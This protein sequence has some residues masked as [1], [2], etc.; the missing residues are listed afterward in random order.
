MFDDSMMFFKMGERANRLT[1]WNAAYLVWREANPLRA[2]DNQ[3]V[4]QVLAQADQYTGNMTRASA[5]GWNYGWASIPT[6]FLATMLVS[7][8]RC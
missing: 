8:I 2:F 7:W 6:Q 1:A 4:K 3:A 5:A